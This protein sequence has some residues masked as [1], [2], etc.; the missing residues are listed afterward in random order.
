MFTDKDIQ[1]EAEYR[2]K[3][4]FAI[5]KL[6][7]EEREKER[8]AREQEEHDKLLRVRFFKFFKHSFKTLYH[9]F[10]AFNS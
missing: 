5:C 2:L 4:F 8:I 7:K 10:F 1:E 9:K 6:L 3:S